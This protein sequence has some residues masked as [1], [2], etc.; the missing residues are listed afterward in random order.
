MRPMDRAPD[1]C[2]LAEAS[3]SVPALRDRFYRALLNGRS[4]KLT[5]LSTT[6]FDYVRVYKNLKDKQ[7]ADGSMKLS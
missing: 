5:F 3:A 2:S 6:G 4:R 7:A 1:L